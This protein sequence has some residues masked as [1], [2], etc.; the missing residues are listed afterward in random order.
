MEEYT[1]SEDM[2]IHVIL[3]KELSLYENKQEIYGVSY[4]REEEILLYMDYRGLC[5]QIS[6]EED[7]LL[8]QW[9]EYLSMEKDSPILYDKI[10]KKIRNLYGDKILLEIQERTRLLYQTHYLKKHDKLDVYE[11]VSD[12]ILY[13]ISY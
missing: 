7:R 12:E 5:R 13:G 6:R 8:T 4:N 11:V 10:C 3:G 1:E 9:I 2:A